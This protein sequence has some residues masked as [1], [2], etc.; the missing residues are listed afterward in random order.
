MVPQFIKSDNVSLVDDAP[1][2]DLGESVGPDLRR[3]E[4]LGADSS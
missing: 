3:G 2:Y 4:L 1:L